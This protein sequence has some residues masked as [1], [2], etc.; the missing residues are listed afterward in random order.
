MLVNYLILPSSFLVPTCLNVDRV[1]RRWDWGRRKEDLHQLMISEIKVHLEQTK[2]SSYAIHFLT[3]CLYFST[4]HKPTWWLWGY[5]N[6]KYT[7]RREMTSIWRPTILQHAHICIECCVDISWQPLE[8]SDTPSITHSASRLCRWPTWGITDEPC[9]LII[10]KRSDA[11]GIN[12]V[13]Q[14]KNDTDFLSINQVSWI[15]EN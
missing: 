3:R 8:D 10:H 7:I 12:T 1:T 6:V 4:S 9:H 15:Y 14:W 2:T 5:R 11:I 13:R